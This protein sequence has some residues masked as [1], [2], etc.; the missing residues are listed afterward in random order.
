MN[1]FQTALTPGGFMRGTL[2]RNGQTVVD[3]RP[4]NYTFDPNPQTYNYN[5]F[6]AFAS[7]NTQ[8][9][10]GQ[11]PPPPNANSTTATA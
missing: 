2:V 6:T 11:A 1:K 9:A 8:G 7:A 3:L 4:Q 10:A 5:A